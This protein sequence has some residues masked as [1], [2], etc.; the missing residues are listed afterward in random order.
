M[1]NIH[2]PHRLAALAAVAAALAIGACGTDDDNGQGGSSSSTTK[3]GAQSSSSDPATVRV[4]EDEFSLKPAAKSAKAGKVTF[5]VADAGKIEHEFVVI[6][7]DKQ[8]DALLKGEEADET[9]AVDEIEDIA[10]GKDAKLTLNLKPGHYALICNL[11]G[12][13]MPNGK[14]GMLADFTVQ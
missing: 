9:G 14:P 7:T 8:A 13:Y 4:T 11:P 2:A 1:S 6:R 12:H 10:P 5:D 3:T